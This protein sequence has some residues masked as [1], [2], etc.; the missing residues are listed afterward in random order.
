MS[1]FE[2]LVFIFE[3]IFD[4]DM[5]LE[6]YQL[7]AF[8]LFSLYG[9]MKA[10]QYSLKLGTNIN[11]RT[12]IGH[13]EFPGGTALHI[14]VSSQ[15]LEMVKFLIDQGIS[16]NERDLNG[17]T[18]LHYAAAG[19]FTEIVEYFYEINASFLITNKRSLVPMHSS[20]MGD[21]IETFKICKKAAE[22]QIDLSKL[23]NQERKIY[24]RNPS[25]AVRTKEKLTPIMLSIINNC[26]RIFYYLLK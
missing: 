10:M 3:Q 1:S 8:H 16:I 9:N 26:E 7:S 5:I 22:E 20:I 15:K 25:L 11:C 4:P 17:N 2:G 21:N 19:G 12:S 24:I 13:K 14:A 23:K 18:A 6:R